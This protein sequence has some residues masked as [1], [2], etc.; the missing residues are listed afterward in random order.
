M[1]DKWVSQEVME[2]VRRVGTCD[3]LIQKHSS[4]KPEDCNGQEFEDWYNRLIVLLHRQKVAYNEL[5][6]IA[7]KAL[8][9]SEKELI[10]NVR[11]HTE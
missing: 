2:K 3:G 4:E 1:G 10:E 8:S 11:K 5:G 7:E 9:K 6:V